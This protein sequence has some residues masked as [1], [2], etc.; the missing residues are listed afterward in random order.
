MKIKTPDGKDAKYKVVP[1][2]VTTMADV[3]K[4]KK[5]KTKKKADKK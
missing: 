4:E 1:T 5:I 3:K 2:K